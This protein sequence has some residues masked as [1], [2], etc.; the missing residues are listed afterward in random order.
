VYEVNT[1]GTLTIVAGNGSYGYAG[2][3]GPAT[4]A[5]LY[6]PEA[7]AVDSAGNVYIADYNNCIIRKVT[8]STGVIS[9]VAGTPNSCGYG[10]DGGAATS[11]Q[12]YLTTGIAVDSSGNLYIPEY[13]YCVVRKV[14]AST[15]KISTIAGDS[16]LGCGF[17]GDGGAATNAQLYEPYGVAVDGSA[18]LYIA[19][20]ENYRIRKV[21]ASTGKITTIA[22]NG[23]GGFSGDG[24]PATSAEVNQVFG[25]ASDSSGNVFIADYYN[26]VIREVT[27]S[28]GKINTVAGEGQ[29]C[30]YSGDGGLAT[31]AQLY[32]PYGVAVNSSDAMFIA[33]YENSRIRK[34]ALAGDI[35]TVAGNGT[36]YYTAATTATGATFQQVEAAVP[37][38]SGNVYIADFSG[39]LV[40]KATSSGAISILAGT[41][42]SASNSYNGCGY[43]GDGG[44][45][46]SAQLYYPGK[47]IVDGA[48]NVYISDS[49]NCIIRKVN[50]SGKISTFAGTAQSCGY[51]GDGGPATSAQLSEPYGIAFDTSGNLYIVD[52]GNNVIREVSAATGKIS[53]VAGNY[54]AGYGYSGDGGPATS[55]QLYDPQDVA[56]DASGNLYIA[57]TDNLRIRIVSGGIID[58]FAGN[59]S[60]GYQADG[61]PATE[62]SIYY[63]SG[64]AVDAAGDVVIADTYNQRVR[65]VDGAG[66]IHTVAGSGDNGFSGDGGLATESC[67]SGSP[68]T[69]I[70]ADL[71]Y[72][73]G[74]GVDPSGN[75]YIADTNNYRVRNV[76]AIPNLN[77]SAYNL[78]FPQQALGTTSDP[79]QLTLTVVGPV[80]IS[81]LTTTGDFTE[82]D[83]CPSS[84]S[85]GQNC[86]VDVT[87]SPSAVG[88]RTGTLTIATNSFFNNNVV[89]KLSGEGGGLTFAPAS[90]SFGNQV[91]GTTSSTHTVTFTNDSTSSV[92]FAS[93][94]VNKTVFTIASNTCTGTLAAG[95]NCAI[96]LTFKPTASGAVEGSLAV[97]DNDTTSP[98]LIP[99][100]GTG[101]GT[102][103]SPTSLAFGTVIDGSS[104]T[105]STTLTNKGTA[106][107]TSISASISGT[108]ASNFT[109]TTC[110]TTLAAGASCTYTVTYKPTGT[111]AQSATL[112]VRDNEGSFPV[113]LSGTAQSTSI[114]PTSLAFGTVTKGST[115]AL[116]T[117]VT[118]K[119]TAALTMSTA[120]VTGT[121]AA[122]FTFTTTCGSSLAASS[123]C[124]Y[125]VTFKPSTTSS[126]SATLN[127]KDNEGSFPVSLTG[128]GD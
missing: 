21:T 70:L 87:F 126:E 34:A 16:S 86:Q 122:D 83:D 1:S 30:T 80:T 44:P 93:V 23:T 108:N 94:S 116:S 105:L 54:T 62:T 89:V 121:N 22:G 14:T 85:S 71:A 49:R 10:G 91:V 5:T 112:T 97:K 50:T 11:A 92:T 4:K 65:F 106:T 6:N 42:P 77:S 15:G 12:L 111:G 66:I 78:S 33:D 41:P 59:G 67:P 19:D 17:S 53:T 63:P 40:W 46:T 72:P 115:K 24:G 103:L 35:S 29:S 125:T 123:S 81:N 128:T 96:G 110:G 73:Y 2:D 99:V 64:V 25:L 79:Q 117:T 8:K 114:S 101:I 75:I 13:A 68:P 69:C 27:A 39:C 88:K 107:I 100:K 84:L 74:V 3:G 20:T 120:T 109:V 95:A 113:S 55:A 36:Q 51:G 48:G 52:E 98:Q 82:A 32:Y 45:A 104:S 28:N 118:D 9:T 31:S 60:G 57:D 7:V 56:I 61:V 76:T 26:C 90:V 18:N 43:S 47:A 124:S 58:T 127:I 119:G 37:D 38:A 102:S